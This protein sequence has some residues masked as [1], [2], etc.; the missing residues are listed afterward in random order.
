MDLICGLGT[1]I[2]LAFKIIA[3]LLLFEESSNRV[4]GAQFRDRN[5]ASRNTLQGLQADLVIDASGSSSRA[6]RWLEELGCQ[7]PHG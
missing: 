1:A 4:Q 7:I 5:H 6:P 3:G 2:V